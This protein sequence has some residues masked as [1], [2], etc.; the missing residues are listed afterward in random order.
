MNDG[1][2]LRWNGTVWVPGQLVRGPSIVTRALPDAIISTPESPQDPYEFQ[3]V[4]QNGV[5]FAAPHSL[6][7][8]TPVSLAAYGLAMGADGIMQGTPTQVATNLAVPLNMVDSVGMAA[9]SIAG[10]LNIIAPVHVSDTLISTLAG[11]AAQVPSSRPGTSWVTGWGS[12]LCG[13]L[14]AYPATAYQDHVTYWNSPNPFPAGQYSRAVIAQLG[15]S[16]TAGG[17]MGV[18]VRCGPTGYYKVTIGRTVYHIEYMRASG[19]TASTA[20]DLSQ[21]LQPFA[22]AVGDTIFFQAVGQVL[23]FKVIRNGNVVGPLPGNQPWIA[24]DT[25]LSGGQP[26]ISGYGTSAVASAPIIKDWEGGAAT[27]TAAAPP[28]VGHVP[29]ATDPFYTAPL[30]TLVGRPGWTVETGTI[31]VAASGTYNNTAGLGLAYWSGA[32]TA[33]WTPNQW[34]GGRAAPVGTPTSGGLLLRYTPGSG[35]GYGVIFNQTNWTLN[36]YVNRVAN[37]IATGTATSVIGRNLQNQDFCQLEAMNN[38]LTFKINGVT[39][40]TWPDNTYSSGVAGFVG[41]GT[42][43]APTGVSSW[44]AGQLV[45]TS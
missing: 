22:F 41:S 33:S 8:W 34:V 35:N 30:G 31:T 38:Q 21:G 3:V 44:A 37:I 6:Y 20:Y 25:N 11:G 27:A 4:G 40:G 39:A 5:P 42:A 28:S 14:G 2:V 19:T 15:A 24:G 12:L 23:T 18:A 29:I 43:A 7:T 36:R 17:W 10:T 16:D 26:G 32:V 13:S 45:V 1:D 9:P